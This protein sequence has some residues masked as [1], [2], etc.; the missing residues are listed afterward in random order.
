MIRVATRRVIATMQN[1]QSFGNRTMRQLPC[2]AMSV[3]MGR[4]TTNHNAESAIARPTPR[5]GPRPTAVVPIDLAPE[6]I[7]F[8]VPFYKGP[9]AP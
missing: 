9:G 5:G 4:T 6:A 1:T 2:H 8:H 7:H 3:N